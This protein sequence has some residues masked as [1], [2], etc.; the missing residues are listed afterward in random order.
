MPPDPRCCRT[1]WTLPTRCRGPASRPSP[2][3][4]VIAHR[5]CRWLGPPVVR[6]SLSGDLLAEKA[7]PQADVVMALAATS[8]ML[9]EKEGMLMPYAPAGLERIDPK[10]RDPNA[11][12]QWVG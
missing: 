5:R 9:L 4:A 7:N 1:V 3:A 2:R 12:P 8:L 10:M 6:L 11:P